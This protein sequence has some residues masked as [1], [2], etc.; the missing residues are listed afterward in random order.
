MDPTETAMAPVFPMVPSG[1]GM[2]TARV[3]LVTPSVVPPCFR[4]VGVDG[5]LGVQPGSVPMG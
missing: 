1:M 2:G 3:P 5:G 4:T